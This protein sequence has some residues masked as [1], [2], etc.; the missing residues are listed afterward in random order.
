MSSLTAVSSQLF[1][2]ASASTRTVWSVSS[3]RT[4]PFITVFIALLTCLTIDLNIPSI[5]G[6]EGGW[7]TRWSL[8]KWALWWSVL[9]SD[10]VRSIVRSIV[11]GFPLPQNLLNAMIKESVLKSP[12]SFKWAARVVRHLNKYL[13]LF[14]VT[15]PLN[16]HRTKVVYAGV[17]EWRLTKCKS[18]FGQGRHHRYIWFLSSPFAVQAVINDLCNE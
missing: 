8:L 6:D 5:C 18:L 12:A 3:G 17:R 1:T 2:I 15:L 4:W 13:H 9:D 14:S 16:I 7:S 11:L 10:K